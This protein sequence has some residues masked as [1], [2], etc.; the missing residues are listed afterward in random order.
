MSGNEDH[1]FVRS[2]W[3]VCNKGDHLEPDV[4]ARFVACEINKEG[5]NDLFNASTPPLEAK[6]FLFARYASERVRDG[7][8]L[9][10]SSVDI[11][12]A[13]LNGIPSHDVFM[14]IHKELKPSANLVARQVR[15][16]YGTPDVGMV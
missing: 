13:Y 11:C 5:K 9:R 7:K 2:R 1:V 12:K 4:R 15:C 6:K 10:L 16:V 8:P 14:S 3:V